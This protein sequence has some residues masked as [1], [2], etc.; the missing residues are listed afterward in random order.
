MPIEIV[1]GISYEDYLAVLPPLEGDFPGMTP[2]PIFRN[3]ELDAS[4]VLTAENS[5]GK[6]WVFDLP[7]TYTPEELLEDD[8]DA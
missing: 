1:D 6:N 5:S 7:P 8:D 3:H 4:K 2:R